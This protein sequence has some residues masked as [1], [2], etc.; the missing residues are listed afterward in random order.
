MVPVLFLQCLAGGFIFLEIVQP[1]SRAFFVKAASPGPLRWIN[2][3]LQP[4]HT[5]GGDFD[6]LAFPIKFGRFV[7]A[8]AAD[9][10]ARVQAGINL[11]IE[12]ENE[13]REGAGGAKE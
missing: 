9:L 8:M 2:F 11:E 7:E 1:A 3:H 5:F 10:N 12:F 4:M 13:V 6:L